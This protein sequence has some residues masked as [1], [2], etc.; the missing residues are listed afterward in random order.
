MQVS[1]PTSGLRGRLVAIL[2][3]LAGI[4][5]GV[6]ISANNGAMSTVFCELF[7]NF[8]KNYLSIFGI[9]HFVLLIPGFQGVR[10]SQLWF[11]FRSGVSF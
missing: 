5:I 11:P 1:M 9:Q 2:A 8:V 10:T 7:I 4:G 3:V 6:G